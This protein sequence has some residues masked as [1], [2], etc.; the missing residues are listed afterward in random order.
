MLLSLVFPWSIRR[1]IL[2]KQLG[3]SI[4]PSCRIGLSW[5]LPTRLIMEEGSTIGHLTMCKNVD[6]LHLGAHST[7]GRGNWITGFPLG[8]S[9]HFSNE[10]D[11]RPELILGQHTA[12]TH[13]H[14]I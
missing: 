12:I 8:P 7:I 11:R 1:S 3:Y 14:L 9:P 13:R 2:E 6:L 4:H 5:I 10:K